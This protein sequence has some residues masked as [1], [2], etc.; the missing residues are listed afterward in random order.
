MKATAELI[1]AIEMISRIE[2]FK[3]MGLHFARESA[4][5]VNRYLAV[6]LRASFG[7]PVDSREGFEHLD[8]YRA[9]QRPVW[10]R[11]KRDFDK[12]R[13]SE[14]ERQ[15]LAAGARLF[16]EK[17]ADIHEELG[18]AVPDGAVRKLPVGF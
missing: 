13:L 3:L 14:P 16:Y 18:V 5:N 8:P 1:D 7:A 12:L 17:V 9:G 15:S 2:P 6:K 10:E 11:F 4:R